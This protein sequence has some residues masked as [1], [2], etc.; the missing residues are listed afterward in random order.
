MALNSV[1]IQRTTR[2]AHPL[3]RDQQFKKMST[4]AP[5][6][7]GGG[8]PLDGLPV[9]SAIRPPAHFIDHHHQPLVS[10]RH[11]LLGAAAA[12]AL[13][14]APPPP[15]L[16]ENV[17]LQDVESPTLRAGLEAATSGR[18]DA[19]ERLF[20]VYL[21]EAPDSA[22]GYSN[23]GNVHLQQGLAVQAEADFTRAIDLWPSAPVPYLNRAIAREQ[24]GVDALDDG[25]PAAAAALWARA[26]A[27]C[28]AAIERDPAEFAAWFDK[29]NVELR[30]A[31]FPAALDSFRRAAD[32]A[33][34]LAGY[35]L[36]YATLLF[37]TGDPGGAAQQMRGLCR[38]YGNYG[39]AHAALAA[40][41]WAAGRRAAAEEA[42]VRAADVDPAWADG[43]EVRRATRWPPKLYDAYEALLTI[44][45]L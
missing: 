16:A 12:A 10:L 8:R 29:G 42:L 9:I 45:A 1:H 36:R 23:L 44:N 35:R 27:D 21:Q 30:T 39:E 32:L 6:A 26:I 22:S 5:R 11:F 41:E 18:L 14:L 43:R 34:G 28:D 19:A 38:K 15:C 3:Q 20:Q 33:P 31:D 24:L 7:A 37:Q 2:Q 13:A 17:R 25:D 4:T 40:V